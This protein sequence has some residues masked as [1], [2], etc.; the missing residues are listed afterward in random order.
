[1]SSIFYVSA[2]VSA[3]GNFADCAYYSDKSGVN[4]LSGSTFHIDPDAGECTFEQTENSPLALIGATFSNLG[5]SPTLS[6]GNF[7]PADGN[8]AIRFAM[9]KTFTVTT[10]V[11]LLFSNPEMVDN[12]YPSSD[13]QVVNDGGSPQSVAPVTA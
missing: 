6:K 7:C 13:P 12:L 10:G 4:K 11:V 1:M 3:D 2:S 8:N 9:P 5:G